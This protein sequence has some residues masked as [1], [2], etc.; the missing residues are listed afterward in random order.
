MF[1]T[2]RSLLSMDDIGQGDR[3]L[4][5]SLIFS[6]RL[7]LSLVYLISSLP[8][9]YFS[10]S[11]F[12]FILSEPCFNRTR[13]SIPREGDQKIGLSCSLC[14]RRIDSI[15]RLYTNAFA[16]VP[17]WVSVH[18][19]LCTSNLY[20][21]SFSF[22]SV[23]FATF[24]IGSLSSLLPFST[25]QSESFRVYLNERWQLFIYQL[26]PLKKKHS[27]KKLIFFTFYFIDQYPRKPISS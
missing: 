9:Q 7:L 19:S 12:F 16:S 14:C 26:F 25:P 6:L 24:H 21:Y 1:L 27:K 18:C 13:N 4:S 17:P 23:I 8:I 15:S 11:F 3:H 10:S 20:C 2:R 22:K 5:F